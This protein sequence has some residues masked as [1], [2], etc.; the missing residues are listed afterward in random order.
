M[1][2]SGERCWPP[3]KDKGLEEGLGCWIL[4]QHPVS[5]S[6]HLPGEMAICSRSGTVCLWTPQDG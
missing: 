5:C 2:A 4:T 1:L 3:G 6:P